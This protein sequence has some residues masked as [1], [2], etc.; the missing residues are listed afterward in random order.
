MKLKPVRVLTWLYSNW[1]PT[2]EIRLT[3]DLRPTLFNM[4][5]TSFL[6]HRKPPEGTSKDLNTIANEHNH[7]NPTQGAVCFT[8]FSSLPSKTLTIHFQWE[9]LIKCLIQKLPECYRRL[10]LMWWKSL[11]STVIHGQALGA[12]P[13]SWVKTHD[14]RY[15]GSNVKGG[16]ASHCLT[17]TLGRQAQR[18]SWRTEGVWGG[19]APPV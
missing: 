15:D 1:L 19:C 9:E 10:A 13:T 16:A 8:C 7:H 18:C 5:A 4:S 17:F 14:F 2:S 11:G 6:R 3:I 12:W